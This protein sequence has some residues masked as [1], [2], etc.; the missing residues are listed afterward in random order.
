MQVFFQ[1]P[2]FHRYL[3]TLILMEVD[4][5]GGKAFFVGLVLLDD[6]DVFHDAI[7][8][9]EE[10]L[11]FLHYLAIQTTDLEGQFIDFCPAFGNFVLNILKVLSLLHDLPL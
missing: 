1:S 5:E 4:Y 11:I 10:G 7:F 3:I 6:L 2:A 9:G 8:E